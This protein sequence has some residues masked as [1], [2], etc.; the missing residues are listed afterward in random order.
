MD[1]DCTTPTR[2]D[3]YRECN[4]V[5]GHSA[6]MSDLNQEFEVAYQAAVSRASH[7]TPRSQIDEK[8]DDAKVSDYQHNG[9][10]L[11]ESNIQITL[12]DENA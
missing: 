4:D 2:H 8:Y 3:H 10:Q 5:F 11:D 1:I 6:V 12:S 7:I 9:D